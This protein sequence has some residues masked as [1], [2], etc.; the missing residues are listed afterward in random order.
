MEA[1]LRQLGVL[2]IVTGERTAPQ[3]PN[4]VEETPATA[5]DAAIPLTREGRALN[6]SLK[7]AYDREMNEFRDRQEKAASDILAHLSRSQRTHV[8]DRQ[9]DLAWM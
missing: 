6:A 4:Y 7:V 2:R 1:C 8:V 3:T 9:D 5:T